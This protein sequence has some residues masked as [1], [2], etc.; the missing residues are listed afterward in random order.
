M[1]KPV[2]E[3]KAQT[4][5]VKVPW[6]GRRGYFDLLLAASCVILIISNIGATK[7]VEFGPL[8]FDLP[9]IGN[10]IVTD[11]GFFLFPLA[12]VIGDLLSEVYG[13]KRARRAIVASFVA[14]AFAAVCFLVIMYLP[15]AGFYENQKSFEA[16]LGPVWQIYAGS[17][18]GYLCGQTLNAWIMVSM[19][20]STLAGELV[21]TLIFC[22]IAAPV[23]GIETPEAFLN[24]VLV[25]YVYKCLV[26]VILMPISYPVI[27]WFK[28]HELEYVA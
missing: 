4:S 6:A 3:S 25:G 14:A 20:V 7:G 1:A 15:A 27:G 12:Y 22:S 26:E 23:L 21:D 13:F 28:R 9:V 2:S 11:G 10:T 18:L 24:Y 16:V 17:L 8:P 19:I 5:T